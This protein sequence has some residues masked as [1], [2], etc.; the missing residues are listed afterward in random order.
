[1]RLTPATRKHKLQSNFNETGSV[2]RITNNNKALVIRGEDGEERRV[3]TKRA[4][5][6]KP[7]VRGSI[8]RIKLVISTPKE[9]SQQQS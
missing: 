3:A 6:L 5:V 2:V 7:A 8:K 1:L 4:R 9:A